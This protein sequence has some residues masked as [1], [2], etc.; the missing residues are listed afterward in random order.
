MC[1]GYMYVTNAADHD[2]EAVA[3]QLV[4]LMAVVA[5]ASWI[6]EVSGEAAASPD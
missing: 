5:L 2:A 4:V 1:K 6:K 3:D